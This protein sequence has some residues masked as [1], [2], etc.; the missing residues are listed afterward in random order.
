MSHNGILPGISHIVSNPITHI[1]NNDNY[2]GNSSGYKFRVNIKQ[3][4][5]VIKVNKNQQRVL[6]S[7]DDVKNVQLKKPELNW[8]SILNFMADK[9][10]E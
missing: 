8:V 10:V 5:S 6:W 7:P 1:N 2:W 9:S 4:A 3:T